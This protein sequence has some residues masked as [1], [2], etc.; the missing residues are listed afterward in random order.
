MIR[1]VYGLAVAVLIS[2]CSQSVETTRSGSTSSSESLRLAPEDEARFIMA[3]A[4]LTPESD[5]AL[6]DGIL[7]FINTRATCSDPGQ[8]PFGSGSSGGMPGGGMPGSG[9][10]F[11]LGGDPGM[12]GSPGSD[13][14]GL[15][16]GSTPGLTGTLKVMANL[17]DADVAILVANIFDDII[18]GLEGLFLGSPHYGLG[19]R[20]ALQFGD[21]GKAWVAANLEGIARNRIGEFLRER[22]IKFVASRPSEVDIDAL[23]AKIAA[24]FLENPEFD[25]FNVSGIFKMDLKTPILGSGLDRVRRA[26]LRMNFGGGRNWPNLKNMVWNRSLRPQLVC[27]I[28]QTLADAEK[29]AEGAIRQAVRDVLR[30]LKATQMLRSESYR[31]S[32]SSPQALSRIYA[33]ISLSE[34]SY[35]IWLDIIREKGL[36]GTLFGLLGD[37]N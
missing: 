27:E 14:G 2:G 28:N 25:G 37:R 9:G 16:S 6:Y 35:E 5:P 4:G 11:F 8:D 15:D 26:I 36:I 33:Q 12:S 10:P 24:W 22:D 21:K 1:F 23:A 3:D 34:L 32:L 13:G 17:S 31:V 7:G 18:A 20:E 19:I 30:R 29:T